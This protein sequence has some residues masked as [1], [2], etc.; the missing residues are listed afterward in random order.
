VAVVHLALPAKER[1]PER[2][3]GVL[4]PKDEEGAPMGVLFNSE[5]FPHVAPA[6]RKLVTVCFGGVGSE[7]ELKATDS[8]LFER[9]ASALTCYLGVTEAT[10]LHCTRWPRGI[11]QHEALLEEASHLFKELSR[12]H[13]GLS[14]IGADCG[15][16]GVPARIEA[17]LDL[18]YPFSK[19]AA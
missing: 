2:G 6:G 7:R 4:F 16:V 18:F 13:P 15:P 5:L 11:P 3:F 14:F 19:A 8:E 17:G 9:A 1:L 10:G 12:K